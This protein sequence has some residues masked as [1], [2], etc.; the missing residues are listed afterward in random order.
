MEVIFDLFAR[1]QIEHSLIEIVVEI[2]N[3]DVILDFDRHHIMRTQHLTVL[4]QLIIDKDQ[5]GEAVI[6]LDVTLEIDTVV[7][8]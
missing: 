3:G 1:I 5:L 6:I 8:G 4:V 7:V 2:L